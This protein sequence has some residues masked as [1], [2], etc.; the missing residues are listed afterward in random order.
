MS[1]RILVVEDEVALQ[2]TLTYTLEHQGY[3]VGVVGDGNSAVKM[4]HSFHPDLVLLDI[5]LPGMDG[6]E[7]CRI[8]RQSM[9]IPIIFLSARED[10]IDRIVGLEIGGD[11][12]IIKPYNT[13]ELLARIKARLRM[14]ELVRKQMLVASQAAQVVEQQTRFGNLT[15]NEKRREVLLDGAPI[16]LN[17]K[18]FELILFFTRHIGRVV[19]RELILQH[20][21]GYG[22]TGDNRT[23]DVHVRW[24]REKIEKD[25]SNPTRILTIRGV[26][27]LFD[28]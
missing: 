6:F 9:I 8:L 24:L 4:A 12:Y 20:V 19:S 25:S 27:Y 14:Q 23:V 17:T 15:I 22:Y 3:T 11:D 5:M 26:G 2:E 28:G 7:V 16:G 18:E 10:E 13:R 1:E 21:W